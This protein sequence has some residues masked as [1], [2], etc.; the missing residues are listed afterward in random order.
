MS[1]TIDCESCPVRGRHCGDCFVPVLARAW[2][3]EPRPR[4][5]EL[6]EEPR[7]RAATMSLDFEE[8]EAV[9]AFARAGLISRVEAHGARAQS[10]TPSVAVG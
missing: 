1:L 7:E 3:E 4:R 9:E 5:L 8:T 2:L 6:A 10:T